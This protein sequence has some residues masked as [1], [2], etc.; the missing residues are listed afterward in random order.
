VG[1]RLPKPAPTDRATR[2]VANRLPPLSSAT[3]NWTPPPPHPPPRAS[4][5][6]TTRRDL[7]RRSH[8]VI[9]AFTLSGLN[10]RACARTDRDSRSDL[11]PDLISLNNTKTPKNKKQKSGPPPG[12]GCGKERDKKSGRFSR[13]GKI[14]PP[15]PPP[16]PPPRSV[17]AASSGDPGRVKA[18]WI[19]WGGVGGG[20]PP[21]PGC[22]PSAAF[23]TPLGR[24]PC[25]RSNRWSAIC[26]CR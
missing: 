3:P 24:S 9:N 17:L 12:G 18:H 16:P 10:P 6:L 20:G 26:L 5:G 2:R 23:N 7:R 1:P 13:S 21:P 15:P 4:G 19:P 14:P 8:P 22:Y 11:N 25:L